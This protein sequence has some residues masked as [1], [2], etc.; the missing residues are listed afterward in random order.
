MTV[1]DR[2]AIFTVLGERE[3]RE[4]GHA[5]GCQVVLWIAH[6]VD[7]LVAHGIDVQESTGALVLGHEEGAVG[8]GFDDRIADA[9]EIG[10]RA[11][12]GVIPA[13]A[14]GATLDDMTCDRAGGE[15]VVLLWSPA[16]LVNQR[17]QKRAR[18]RC[19]GR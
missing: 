16:E 7:E 15:L 14:L 3:A 10:N 17:A 6:L 5:V 4:I 1:V 18:G 9:C 8:V 11:P 12:V 19:R 2:Y 13:R